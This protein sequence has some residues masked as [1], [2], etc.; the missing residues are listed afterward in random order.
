MAIDPET[1]KARWKY[2]LV[3]NDLAAGVLATGGGVLF[4]ATP[5]G[6]LLALDAGTG[7][8]LW[9]FY[10]GASIPSSPISYSVDGRQYVAVS[11]ANVLYSFAL[12]E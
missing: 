1:G 6:T 9:H 12:P 7:A 8:P 11:S 3:Q 2:E 5:E 4:A 10:A